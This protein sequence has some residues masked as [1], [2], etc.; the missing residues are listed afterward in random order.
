MTY[1]LYLT[2]PLAAVLVLTPV[3][4][5]FAINHQIV[6]RQN[7]R[8]VHQGEMAKLG[9]GAIFTAFLTGVFLLAALSGDLFH[10]HL[11]AFISLTFGA[12]ALFF[13]GA[14]DDKADLNCNLKLLIEISAATLVVAFGWRIES[15]ILPA[16]L[17]INLGY[18][19]YPLSILW[20][21][22]VTNSFNMIDGL[23]GLAAGIAVVVLICSLAIAVLFSNALIQPLIFILLGATIGF[24]RYNFNPAS[25]FMGDSG[26]LS[27]G[28]LL[29]CITMKASSVADGTTS[30]L[31]PL[32]LLGLP[33]TDTTLAIIRRWRRGIHPFHAD[34]EHIHHRL[35]NLGL[36]HSGAAT[37]MVGLS[38]ILGIMAYLVAHGIYMDLQ[39]LK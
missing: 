18:F 34:R 39:L 22:G 8:T 24:L 10:Q 14:V 35:V 20:I 28:F 19:S 37:T 21:V 27:V 23:D 29:A 32:L 11:G 2:A 16:S 7:H 36:S 31:I 26:S 3:F 13:L 12:M 4:R 17:Q 15:L 5:R 33:L 6:A 30:L 38:L 9:G 1:F 25:I